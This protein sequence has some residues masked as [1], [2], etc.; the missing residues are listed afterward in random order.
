MVMID[1]IL[2]PLDG[3]CFGEESVPYAATLAKRAALDVDLIHVHV[4]H[5]P[6]HLLANTQYQFEG[7]SMDVYDEK[8]RQHERAYLE[9][10]AT[11]TSEVSGHEVHTVML[12]GTVDEAIDTCAC[13]CAPGLILMSTHGRTGISRAWRGSVA[14]SLVRHT[15]WPL[16][17]VRPSEEADRDIQ[18]EHIL[19]PLDGSDRSQCILSPA[20]DLAKAMGSRVKLLHV[21]P[22]HTGFGARF[23]RLSDALT[24]VVGSASDYLEGIAD[25]M[26]E[27]GITVD[28]EV[29]EDA[30]PARGII[31]VVERDSVD[32]VALATHGYRGVRR[33]ILGSVADKVLRRAQVP[34]LLVGPCWVGERIAG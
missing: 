15:S 14:D 22:T 29:L 23:R 16:L 10:L 19:V 7:V 24:V 25:R 27:K 17:L 2:V 3:S 1:K 11:K 26:R 20:M 33:A 30:H 8:D 12:D 9:A 31:E 34:L 4:P 5:P 6:D 28:V 13:G 32:L 21:V 18:L